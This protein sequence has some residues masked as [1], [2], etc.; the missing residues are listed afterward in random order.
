MALVVLVS[1]GLFSNHNSNRF[2]NHLT[3]VVL[4]RAIVIMH[5]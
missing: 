3:D 1:T 5:Y 2:S 4:M